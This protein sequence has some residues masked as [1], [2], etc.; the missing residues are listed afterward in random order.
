M[1][2]MKM[3]A[4]SAVAQSKDWVQILAKYREPRHGRSIFELVVTLLPFLTLWG[5]AWWALSYSY[6]LAL[7]LSALNGA[8]V[9]RIFVIQHDCGHYS[10]FK[11]RVANDWVGRCLG[12]LTV[13]PH[14][15]WRKSHAQHHSASGNL[16]QRGMGEI[17]TMTVAEYR[18]ASWIKKVQYR[19][20]R[21]P[22]IL[23][24]LAP[25]Y[26]FLLQNRLP[27]GF[28][29]SGVAYWSSAFG[30]NAM[31]LAI[32]AAVFQFGGLTPLLLIFLPSIIVA[33]SIGV[34]LFYI[35][36]QFEDG[37]WDKAEDWD[38]HD[39]ALHGSSHYVLPG[40]LQ[41]FSAN[42]G[43]HHVHHLYSRIPF[44]R[45]TEVLRDQPVLEGAQRMTIRES[46]ANV[47]L[48]L[49]DENQRRLMTYAEARAS[50]GPTA[51]S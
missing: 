11:S 3:A 38:V 29:R 22:I 30:T 43:I 36:H 49:W 25:A 27:I 37:H 6:T 18:A 28:M 24:G 35:Q 32:L 4:T 23:F 8:F 45:L 13:T 44:Y 21:N 40:V 41:W 10:F 50:Y 17:H 34:W 51:N 46:I 7:L 31:I 19:L 47:R 48:R 26:I 12:V 14:L 33:A 15:I 1:T 42:I 5:L 20:Y 39:A 2:D 9:I 16:D